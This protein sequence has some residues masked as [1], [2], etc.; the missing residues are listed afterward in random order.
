MISD[1]V[2]KELENNQKVNKFVFTIKDIF[3]DILWRFDDD[4]SRSVYL[5]LES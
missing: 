2:L 1:K 3:N 5:N 4:I